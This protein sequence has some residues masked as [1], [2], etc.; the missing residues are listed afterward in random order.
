LNAASSK[1]TPS[2]P[3]DEWIRSED[4][5]VLLAHNQWGLFSTA[6]TGIQLMR[7]GVCKVVGVV[8]PDQVGTD[9]AASVGLSRDGPVPVFA[10]LASLMESL[11][12]K[13]TRVL[14]AVSPPGGRLP[15]DMRED[16]ALA[17]RS[18]IPVLSGLH[19]FLAE[20]PELASLAREHGTPLVDLRR[21]PA[22]PVVA[23]GAGRSIPVPVVTT[24]GTDCRSGKMTVAVALREAAKE[25]GL[26]PA[27]VATGQTG[28][29]LQPDAG[30]PVDRVISDFAA[31]EVERQ[32]L[33]AARLD[34]AGNATKHTPDLIIVEGQGAL[35]HP[36]YAGVTMAVL[37]GSWPDALVLTHVHG[38]TVK[39]IPTVGPPFPVLHPREEI[40]LTEGFMEAV[41]PVRVAAVALAAPDLDE[42]SHEAACRGLQE[43]TGLPVYDCLRHGGRP[44]LRAVL[45]AVSQAG[46]KHVPR[47][48][49][50]EGS[51]G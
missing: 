31:G 28:L 37:H 17:I 26:R 15:A 45:N 2:L 34:D 24:I 1:E 20:D 40:G 47:S 21:P 41:H 22:D 29:L 30:A 42:S 18:G 44:L 25:A 33:R 16:V 32:V 46:Q 48:L 3:L 19:T 27:F 23:T 38:R 49:T 14:I 10:D 39:T 43:E 8:N 9:A 51:S 5:V 11:S 7:Y 4:R 12:R 13:P 35:S 50:Q 6:K 36:A